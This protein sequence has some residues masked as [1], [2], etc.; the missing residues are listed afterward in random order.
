[1]PSMPGLQTA[2]STDY[3]T[4]QLTLTLFLAG[5][6]VAQLVHGPLS[7]RFGRRPVLLWGLALC[8]AASLAGAVAAGIGM[9]VLARV[10]QAV[11]GSAGM[12]VGR[13]I[14]RDLYSRDKAASMLAYVTMAMVVMPMIAPAVGGFLDE[15][16]GWRASFLAV[17]A[18]SAAVLAITAL[19]VGETNHN[20]QSLPGLAPMLAS[21]GML[22]RKPAFCFYS[23]QLGFST[24]V[25]FSFLGGAPYVMLEL[26][27]RP[28]SEY[29]L[30]FALSALGYMLG[31]FVA[32]RRSS[33]WG[34]WRM[35]GIGTTCTLVGGLLLFAQMAAGLL[36][37]LGMFIAMAVITCG[38][39]MSLPNGLAGAVSV[40]PRAAGAASGLAG[41]LQMA[42][43]AVAS[44]WVGHL[45]KDT[46]WP[47]VLFMLG[48]A[49]LAFLSWLLSPKEEPNEEKG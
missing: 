38:N 27:G 47:L 4:V 5:M 39:G 48:A 1:M 12:V 9:L 23:A 22:L 26:M 35:I 46:A 7:D 15:W 18:L 11:G 49:I 13:V 44:L 6:A 14:L 40:E 33:Q 42:L 43:G 29:G 30:Y 20:R 31:N 10:V 37:P 41:F 16:F 3:G 28:P 45:L 36:T 19:T 25:F 32:G 2:F 8:L 17:A 21:Y 34:N 24:A